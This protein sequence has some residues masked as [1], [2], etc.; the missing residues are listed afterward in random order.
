[1]T[2]VTP[3]SPQL[4]A[5]AGPLRGQRFPLSPEAET[6][7]GRDTT[8]TIVVLDSSIS[9]NHC[10]V[11]FSLDGSYW[12]RDCG[13]RNKTFV[14]GEP[15]AEQRLENGDRILAG[16]SEFIFVS[17]GAVVQV[18]EGLAEPETKGETVVLRPEQA[19]YL[20]G[21]AVGKPLPADARTVRDLDA[22]SGLSR[23]V[24]ELRVLP[25]LEDEILMAVSRVFPAGRAA[26]LLMNPLDPQGPLE[27]RAWQRG[28]GL[29]AQFEASKT[30]VERIRRESVAILSNDT[31]GDYGDARSIVLSRVKRVLAVPLVAFG[32]LLGVL[33]MDSDA[34][35]DGG[36][37]FDQG[38][39]QLAAAFGSVA[40]LAIEN[41]RHFEWLEGENRRL[42]DELAPEHSLVGES[43]ALAD[44]VQF[45]ARVAPTDA[46]VL[47]T[48][49]S[50]TGKELV[51]RA[52]HRNSGRAQKPFVV[53]NCASLTENLL[54][55]ELFGH[56]KGAFT[57]AVAQKKGKIELAEGGTVFLDE[58]GE[59][60]LAVQA[61]LLRVLQER[62]FQR[63]GGNRT[64]HVNIRIL[65]ATN[66]D[67]KEMSRTGGT[68]GFRQDLYFR[69]NVVSVRMPA[70]RERRDDIPALASHFV[71]KAMEKVKRKVTGISPKAHR[72]MARYDWPGNVRELENAIE[73][74]LVMGASELI[75]PEDLPELMLEEAMGA[76]VGGHADVVAAG[77]EGNLLDDAVRNAKR[78][79]IEQT[80]DQTGGNQVEAARLLGIHAV[81]LSR[82][83]KALGIKGRRR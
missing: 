74:A 18:V 59:V 53:I 42:N 75:Q 83:M 63:V 38:H 62:E 80:L 76:A 15:V 55:S 21:A 23:K 29:G 43:A 37:A 73:R 6:T 50:G 57:G 16:S 69:L 64:L 39:L 61:K 24:A 82:L 40:A 7:I 8:N 9:R 2:T 3:D 79:V 33:Y 26:V 60:P 14:N 58:I 10:K 71:T 54:E 35:S 11:E 70:L 67:L 46:T 27:Q 13:S 12:V 17:N 34:D 28:L 52:I 45:I 44:V 41:A 31:L 65:A 56:E 66:R 78:T 36:G 20:H 81:H 68:G 30:I 49:E 25:E 19:I 47:I 51:A 72:L 77:G 5:I 4:E 32:N 48:G 22:L 1:M